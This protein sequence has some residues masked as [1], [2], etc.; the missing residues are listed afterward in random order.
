MSTLYF[1][2]LEAYEVL[3]GFFPPSICLD[4]TKSLSD[5]LFSVSELL[6]TTVFKQLPNFNL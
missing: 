1:T 6:S 2:I 4:H 3:L 5:L